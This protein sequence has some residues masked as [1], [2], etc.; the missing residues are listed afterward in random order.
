LTENL[1]SFLLDFSCSKQKFKPSLQRAAI[2]VNGFVVY[3]TKERD[4]QLNIP[5]IEKRFFFSLNDWFC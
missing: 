1:G 5:S 3:K 2:K 4:I